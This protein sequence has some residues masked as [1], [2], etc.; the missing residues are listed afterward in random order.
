MRIR[1]RLEK[2]T[3]S[4][5]DPGQALDLLRALSGLRIDLNVLTATRIGMTVNALR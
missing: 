2:M 5:Q 3:S 4:E 1:K